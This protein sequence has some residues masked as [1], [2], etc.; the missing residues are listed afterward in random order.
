MTAKL[1]GG[2]I[3]TLYI[4]L[5]RQRQ[6]SYE[7]ARRTL[8]LELIARRSKVTHL[9]WRLHLGSISRY[10]DISYCDPLNDVRKFLS[11]LLTGLDV[12]SYSSRS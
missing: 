5:C 6:A 11:T 1:L 7:K 4:Y 9:V 2:E 3:K 8:A 12:D 10:G